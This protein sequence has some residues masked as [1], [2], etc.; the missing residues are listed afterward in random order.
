VERA[1]VAL[2]APLALVLPGCLTVTWSAEAQLAEPPRAARSALQPGESD[3]GQAL[4]ALGAPLFVWEEP[5][6]GAALAWGWLA[7]EDVGLALSL[8]LSRDL[9]AS[10]SYADVDRDLHGLVLSFDEGWRLVRSSEGF[11]GDLVPA[12]R[13]PADEVP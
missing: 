4:A 10:F 1:R 11:L 5:D 12:R 9:A 6:G 7:R 13:R 3:L 2:L 8:P